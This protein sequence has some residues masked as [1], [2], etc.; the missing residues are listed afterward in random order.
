MF[1]NIFIMSC[2]DVKMRI[3][4]AEM[5]TKNLKNAYMTIKKKYF[6]EKQKIFVKKFGL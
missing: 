1:Y 6:E 5:L 3:K 2:L 4:Y